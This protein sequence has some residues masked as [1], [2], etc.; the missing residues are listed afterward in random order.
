MLKRIDEAKECDA[1]DTNHIED[2]G[3][4]LVTNELHAYEVKANEIISLLNGYNLA[5]AQQIL[6]VA[7]ACLP[8]QSYVQLQKVTQ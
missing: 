4:N 3:N 7:K 1:R 2:K 5:E 8:S 6:D